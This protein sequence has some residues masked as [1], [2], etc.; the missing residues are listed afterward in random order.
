MRSIFVKMFVKLMMR[1][2]IMR[3]FL[4]ITRENYL[5]EGQEGFVQK[6]RRLSIAGKYTKKYT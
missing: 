4:E 5:I 2:Y 6:Y 1:K 3:A